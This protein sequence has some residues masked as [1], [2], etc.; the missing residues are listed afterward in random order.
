MKACSSVI[1]YEI[2]YQQA[3]LTLSN[4]A[5]NMEINFNSSID[6]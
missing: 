1:F 4:L 3:Y 6:K 2:F 5:T